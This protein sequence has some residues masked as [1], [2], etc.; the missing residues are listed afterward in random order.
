MHKTEQFFQDAIKVETDDCVWWPFAKTKAGYGV[1]QARG[2]LRYVHRLACES[3][4]G[5]PPSGYQAAHECGNRACFN[6]SHV[7][8][9]NQ[10]GNEADKVLQGRSN[11]GERCG[12]A[13]LTNDQVR[14]ILTSKGRKHR[15][16][17]AEYGVARSR[18][19][20]ILN[21]DGWDEVRS[22]IGRT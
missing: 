9:K 17:A 3:A 19:T 1:F 18:I 7:A 21:G 16:M 12:T 5:A 8:W 11:L 2:K 14:A 4:N 15:D 10:S 22:H 20:N 13:K 6:P